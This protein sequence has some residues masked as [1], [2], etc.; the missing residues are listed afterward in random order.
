[1]KHGIPL[2]TATRW[3]LIALAAIAVFA[4]LEAAEDVFAPVV[5]G[6]VIGVVLSPVS[7]A[8]ARLGAPSWLSALAV[9]AISLLV[10]AGILLFL[11]PVFSRLFAA[12]PQIW[13]EL[14][15][16]IRG[17][18]DMLGV[19][20]TG[21]EEVVRAISP[22]GA[23][24]ADNEDGARVPSLTDAI[25][26]APAFAAQL[27]IFIGT[28]FFFVMTQDEIY[29]W[30][31]GR[32]GGDEGS[33]IAARLKEADGMVSRYFLAI[34]VINCVFG[35]CVAA[36]LALIDMP[37][38]LLWGVIATLLNFILYL[39]PACVT[40]MLLVA[41]VVV[42]DGIAVLLPPVLFVALNLTEGQFV[43][44]ALIGR[45]MSVNPL[46]VFFSLVFWLWLWGP[47][48]GF[49]AIPL[50]LWVLAFTGQLPAPGGR[51]AYWA[52]SAASAASNS[53]TAKR[54]SSQ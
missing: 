44:P 46:L 52:A 50:L 47:L 43:T 53:A 34:T 10:L 54:T 3:A 24:A 40:V 31:A 49:I 4:A 42:F 48:G 29:D 1:M 21:A 12:A 23:A 15:D 20:S 30:I 28:L 45:R 25:F 41:G 35:G 39:G 13:L 2:E 38:P 6:L 51:A 26:A 27:L 7:H 16:S 9:M 18:Q 17:L 37:Q 19:I 8:L 22:D 14:R 5:L 32:I 11:G 36:A 33:G